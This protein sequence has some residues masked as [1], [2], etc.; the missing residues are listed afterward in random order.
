MMD[1]ALTGGEKMVRK[2]YDIKVIGSNLRE[3]RLKNNL[4]IE[5]VRKYMQLGTVQAVY[6]WERGDCLPQADSLLALMELYGVNKIDTITGE[7]AMP[8]PVSFPGETSIEKTSGGE[9]FTEETFGN[10]T[11]RGETPAA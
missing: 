5:D 4:S 10:G 3:L 11:F 7:G 6:K 9:T 2:E 8:A 1:A